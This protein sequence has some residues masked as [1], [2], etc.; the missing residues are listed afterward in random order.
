MSG[1]HYILNDLQAGMLAE[2][3]ARGGQA[4]FDNLQFVLKISR[5]TAQR[6]LGELRER[7]FIASLRS[8]CNHKML[9][10]MTD[11]GQIALDEHRMR[12]ARHVGTE[13]SVDS[14]P[15]VARRSTDNLFDAP[16]Y[17]PQNSRTYYRNNGNAHIPSRGLRC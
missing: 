7:G 1:T 14:K 6:E 8:S 9:H 2:V 17:K 4:T 16:T 11:A 15:S 3:Q 12:M 5:S 13:A 10:A